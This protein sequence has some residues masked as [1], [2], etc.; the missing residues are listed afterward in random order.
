MAGAGKSCA[1]VRCRY[2]Q[3]HAHAGCGL[4]T[5][6]HHISLYCTCSSSRL[7]RYRSSPTILG[8]I[9]P[10][11]AIRLSDKVVLPWST[12][13]MMHILRTRSCTLGNRRRRLL[14]SAIGAQ[15]VIRSQSCQKIWHLLGLQGRQLC[16]CG[17][18]FCSGGV[19]ILM[20]CT[21]RVTRGMKVIWCGK[22]YLQQA[23]CIYTFFPARRSPSRTC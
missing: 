10:L 5:V 13:A 20:H 17:L 9:R 1:R 3:C 4:G 18:H 2:R 16:C 21:I 19:L 22:G 6:H 23:H 15:L 12:C 8:W 14:R 11:A 7:S